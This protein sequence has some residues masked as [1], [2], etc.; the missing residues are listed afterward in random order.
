[1]EGYSEATLHKTG[2]RRREVI[3]ISLKMIRH[4]YFLLIIKVNSK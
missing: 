1:M 4:G 2:V 3:V